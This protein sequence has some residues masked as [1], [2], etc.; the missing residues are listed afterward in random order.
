MNINFTKEEYRLLVEALYQADWVMHAHDH[1]ATQNDHKK[2]R[3]KLLSHYKEMAAEDIIEYSD[4]AGGHFEL[5]SFEEELQK[6]YIEPYNDITFWEDLLDHLSERDA[7]KKVGI[8]KYANMDGMDRVVLVED[9][10]EIY[11]EEFAKNGIENVKV[12]G[13]QNDN[14]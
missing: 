8:E 14:T 6:K 2:L 7:I 4:E 11:R 3:E 13:L 9:I 1:E 5:A 10:K 12:D